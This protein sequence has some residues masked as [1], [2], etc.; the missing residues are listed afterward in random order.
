MTKAEEIGNEINEMLDLD[1]Y[2]NTRTLDL[3]DA[4]SLYCYILR[5]D[6]KYTLYQVRDSLRAKGKKFD[7]CSV[8]HNVEIY[9]EVRRRK[10][11]LDFIRDNILGGISPKYAILKKLEKIDDIEKLEQILN[12]INS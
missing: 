3:V 12:F 8:L 6:L 9:D 11:K 2:Q 7:H 4:R 5:K 1:I 10:P